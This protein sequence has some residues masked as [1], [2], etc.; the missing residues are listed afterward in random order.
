[1]KPFAG[2]RD[3]PIY[4]QMFSTI[5][6]RKK[7]FNFFCLEIKHFFPFFPILTA[8]NSLASKSSFQIAHI[9][10]MPI[11]LRIRQIEMH[12]QTFCI[13]HNLCSSLSQLIFVVILKN[14]LRLDLLR[15]LGNHLQRSTVY[16]RHYSPFLAMDF[17]AWAKSSCATPRDPRSP[18]KA[19]QL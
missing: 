10:S 8:M 5:G 1:M 13:H 17:R 16:P 4:M 19:G 3:M 9:L 7:Y 2:V 6:V 18:S 11:L 14:Y 15:T 12:L